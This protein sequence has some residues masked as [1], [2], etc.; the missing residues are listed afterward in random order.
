MRRR[1]TLPLIPILLAA[2]I[3]VACARASQQ[4]EEAADVRMT[5][6][7]SPIPPLV[8]ASELV[9]VLTD[10][11]GKPIEGATLDVIGDMDQAGMEPILAE[12][13]ESSSGVYRV[14][15]EWTMAGD[16]MVTIEATLPDGTTATRE[17][18]VSVAQ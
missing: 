17:F 9:I 8:G 14:P 5:M 15:F 1:V 3:L 13:Q 6:A 7:V 16:W 4:P 2:L 18:D 11:E 10:A 12:A